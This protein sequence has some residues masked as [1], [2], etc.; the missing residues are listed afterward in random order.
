MQNNLD[1]PKLPPDSMLVELYNQL[2]TLV[3]I[4][5]Q[6]GNQTIFYEESDHLQED[7]IYQPKIIETEARNQT[8][9]NNMTKAENENK[10]EAENETEAESE[11][12]K[13]IVHLSKNQKRKIEAIQKKI[14][15]EEETALKKQ[16]KEE[17]TAQKKQK[18]KKK[19]L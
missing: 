16:K 12:D 14:T 17:E 11:S 10:T 4:H 7:E 1:L 15:R 6:T 19:K 5:E 2:E 9:A 18:K 8:K 3:Q 13:K